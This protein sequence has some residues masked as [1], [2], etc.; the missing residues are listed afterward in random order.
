MDLG[1]V[2]PAQL[3]LLLLGPG[4]DRDPDVAAGVFAAYHE[5]NLARRVGWDGGVGILGDGEDLLAVFLELGNQRQVK[6]LV[7]SCILSV[8]NQVTGPNV[9]MR[10]FHG[11]RGRVGAT[12]WIAAGSPVA[13]TAEGGMALQMF[14]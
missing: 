1:V 6:P 8:S 10:G 11:S 7:L 9:E 13:V 14:P 5:A 4:A 3:L 2:V 12:Q